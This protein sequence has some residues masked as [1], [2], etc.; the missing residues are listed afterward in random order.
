MFNEA[1]WKDGEKETLK[2]MKKQGYEILY[3]NFSC[4]G[5]ELDIVA[6]LKKSLQIKNLKKKLK[7]NLKD[8]NCNFSSKTL[9]NNYKMAKN[10]IED[11]ILV[12][13][14]VK[15]RA[16][17][18]FGTGAF[19]VSKTKIEHLKRGAK[20]LLKDKRFENMQVRF[21]VSSVDSGVVNYIEDAF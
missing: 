21:D 4:V 11:D 6:V 13:T 20:F 9:K 8:K 19:A 18:K 1:T 15:S 5:V 10:S 17:D 14:E 2:Y 16:S 3:T 12:I 7:Q